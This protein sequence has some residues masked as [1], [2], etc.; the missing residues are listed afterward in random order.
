MSH[1]WARLT[2]ENQQKAQSN[3]SNAFMHRRF[4]EPSHE[5]CV[6]RK[7]LKDAVRFIDEFIT[8]RTGCGAG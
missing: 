5:L 1:K 4:K 7:K 2:K 3:L 8:R 6:V